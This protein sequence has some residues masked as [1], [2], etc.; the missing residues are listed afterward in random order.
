MCVC[1]VCGLKVTKNKGAVR[2]AFQREAALTMS[3]ERGGRGG[4]GGGGAGEG[5][6]HMTRRE[7]VHV[8]ACVGSTYEVFDTTHFLYLVSFCRQKSKYFLVGSL[9]QSGNTY[10][11]S[12]FFSINW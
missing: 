6:A 8:L 12:F 9:D 10:F 5:H 1:G 7:G 11:S 3:I 2:R 4:G